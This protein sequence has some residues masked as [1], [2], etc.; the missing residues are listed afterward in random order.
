MTNFLISV[1]K[2]SKEQ[3]IYIMGEMKETAS[4][5]KYW[6]YFLISTAA[7]IALLIFIPEWFWLALPFSLTYLAAA[8][9]VM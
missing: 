3:N 6:L 9:D 8:M 1:A 7:M 5:A 4:K 2:F